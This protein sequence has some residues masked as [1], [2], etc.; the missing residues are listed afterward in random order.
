LGPGEIAGLDAFGEFASIIRD[1][2]AKVA[3]ATRTGHEIAR[4]NDPQGFVVFA[5][6]NGRSIPVVVSKAGVLAPDVNESSGAVGAL[7]II[8]GT[9]GAM[10]MGHSPKGSL[11]A[12]SRASTMELVDLKTRK[13]MTTKLPAGVSQNVENSVRV[14][15]SASLALH[16]TSTTTRELDVGT[17]RPGAVTI[18]DRDGRELGKVDDAGCS[19][20]IAEEESGILF[21]QRPQKGALTFDTRTG[22]IASHGENEKL[23]GRLPDGRLVLLQRTDASLRVS[24]SSDGSSEASSVL[25]ELANGAGQVNALTSSAPSNLL[26]FAT[27]GFSCS[28]SGAMPPPVFPNLPCSGT[29]ELLIFVGVGKPLVRLAMATI[30]SIVPLKN[31]ASL[32]IGGASGQPSAAFFLAAGSSELKA[33]STNTPANNE[34]STIR[35]LTWV[36]GRAIVANDKDTFIVDGE[37]VTLIPD[38]PRSTRSI[39]ASS[40]R[41]IVSLSDSDGRRLWHGRP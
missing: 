13:V 41:G 32:I 31:D 1:D 10:L 15:E 22:R 23:H 34:G 30:E 27:G 7:S 36:E 18:I 24:A 39:I 25:L 26:Y 8:N 35:L 12:I 5:V 21:C 3:I 4:T 20:T 6:A 40:R 11:V 33:L 2:G 14:A 9:D 19:V 38:G 17:V 37:Q 16:Q 29:G 28:P